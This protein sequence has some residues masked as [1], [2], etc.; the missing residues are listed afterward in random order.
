MRGLNICAFGIDWRFWNQSPA[1]TEGWLYVVFIYI[2][3][4]GWDHCMYVCV[5][6]CVCVY[7]YIYI[8]IWGGKVILF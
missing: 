6:V 2:F 8:Y 1:G 7:I 5:C 3:Y 4:Y